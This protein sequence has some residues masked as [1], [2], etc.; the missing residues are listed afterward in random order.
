[1]IVVMNFQSVLQL[2]ES[3][4]PLLASYPPKIPLNVWFCV[5]SVTASKKLNK[6][7]SEHKEHTAG[8]FS[9][10]VT[11]TVLSDSITP[12]PSASSHTHMFRKYYCANTSTANEVT[13]FKVTLLAWS[14]SWCSARNS[15][16]CFIQTLT[17]LQDIRV[18][19]PT[20][21]W[22]KLETASRSLQACECSQWW[23]ANSDF[24]ESLTFSLK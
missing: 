9:T 15:L 17:W 22:P 2:Y 6:F 14:C 21:T 20:L 3:S 5:P 12:C 24:G 16:L 19:V 1:M 13:I 11:P 23:A 18:H 4:G 7:P 8:S 10:K